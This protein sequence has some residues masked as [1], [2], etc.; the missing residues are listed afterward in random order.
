MLRM[1][2]LPMA[3][4]GLIGLWVGC[5]LELAPGFTALTAFSDMSTTALIPIT[6]T[7]DRCRGAERSASTTSKEMRREMDEGT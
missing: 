4:T 7:L 1:T 5:F 6:V 3:T 2:V